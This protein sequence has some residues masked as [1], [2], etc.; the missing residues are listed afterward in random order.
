MRKLLATA[1]FL[2]MPILAAD[3]TRLTIHVV[4]TNDKPVGNAS[5]IVKFKHGLNPIKMSKIRTSWE[6]RTSQEGRASVPSLPKGQVLIQIIAKNY[7]TFGEMY[8]VSED[9]RTI[10]I[11]LNPP[12]SQYSAHDPH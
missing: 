5:V 2:A 6:M 10:E 3:K 12:Q 9:E 1:L 4:N 11:K 7:Q 8:D